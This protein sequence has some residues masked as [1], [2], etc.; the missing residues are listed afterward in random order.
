MPQPY[1]ESIDQHEVD[2][3]HPS[4]RPAQSHIGCQ[5]Q[6]VQELLMPIAQLPGHPFLR[7]NRLI[8]QYSGNKLAIPTDRP[9]QKLTPSLS[10]G[11]SNKLYN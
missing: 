2:Q 5:L 4:H 11:Y 7:A 6:S 10:R 1:N 9:F 3:D 8:H